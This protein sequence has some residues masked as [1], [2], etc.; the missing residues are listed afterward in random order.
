[1]IAKIRL[2]LARTRRDDNESVCVRVC[3]RGG[4][5]DTE[6]ILLFHTIM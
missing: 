1:M 3:G 5:A 4:G 6:A 2:Y